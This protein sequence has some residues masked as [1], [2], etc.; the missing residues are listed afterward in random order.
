MCLSKTFLFNLV[1][2]ATFVCVSFTGS[3]Q[4]CW[5]LENCLVGVTCRQSAFHFIILHLLQEL[6]LSHSALLA[7]VSTLCISSCVACV[8]LLTVGLYE[9]EISIQWKGNGRHSF[10]LWDEWTKSSTYYIWSNSAKDHDI[11]N[12]SGSRIDTDDE[13][14]YI[15]VAYGPVYA[16]YK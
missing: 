6:M 12:K 4:A 10:E 13:E 8:L 2:L 15:N 1:L 11:T 16:V 3:F 14:E 5:L 7:I 9:V